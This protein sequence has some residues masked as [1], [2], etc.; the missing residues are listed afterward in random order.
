M[1]KCRER[2]ERNAAALRKPGAEDG[3]RFTGGTELARKMRAGEERAEH[4]H[5]TRGAGCVERSGSTDRS[6]RVRVE[7]FEL[8]KLAGFEARRKFEGERFTGG[9]SGA[10]SP[11]EVGDSVTPTSVSTTRKRLQARGFNDLDDSTYVSR[12]CRNCSTCVSKRCF[13]RNRQDFCGKNCPG[14]KQNAQATDLSVLE[15]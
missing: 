7:G 9:S 12:V 6:R 2:S 1:A 4:E 8:A 5:G 14:K 15:A 3:E 13:G 10:G 11:A